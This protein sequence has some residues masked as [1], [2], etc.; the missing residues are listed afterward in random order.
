MI[1]PFSSIIDQSCKWNFGETIVKIIRNCQNSQTNKQKWTRSIRETHTLQ[2]ERNAQ[3]KWNNWQTRRQVLKTLSS[4][5]PSSCIEH[6]WT[7][8]KKERKEKFTWKPRVHTNTHTGMDLVDDDQVNYINEKTDWL[9]AP[10]IFNSD[11]VVWIRESSNWLCVVLFVRRLQMKTLNHRL[12]AKRLWMFCLSIGLY[13]IHG[14]R[15]IKLDL[16]KF[17]SNIERANDLMIL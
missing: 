15:A 9:T 10:G 16:T 8:R 5:Q 3:R 1:I 2:V 12:Y 13:V 14:Q 6:E 7:N 11:K 4:N 17:K